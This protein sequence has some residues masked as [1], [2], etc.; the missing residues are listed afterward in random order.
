MVD[1]GGNRYA[2]CYQAGREKQTRLCTSY[3]G[4]TDVCAGELQRTSISNVA[5]QVP[6]GLA[7]ATFDQPWFVYAQEVQTFAPNAAGQLVALQKTRYAYEPALQAGTAGAQQYGN[8][9]RVEE[10]EGVGG[11]NFAT[12]PLRTTTTRYYP[13]DSQWLVNQPAVTQVYTGTTT[14]FAETRHYY[15]NTTNYALAPIFGQLKR[16]ESLSVL[17]GAYQSNPASVSQYFEYENGNLKWT[18]DANGNQTTYFYD[19]WYKAFR[20]CAQNAANLKAKATY[21]GVPGDGACNPTAGSALTTPGAAFGQVEQTEDTNGVRNRTT[22]DG[23]GRPQTVTLATGTPEQA[24]Q[25]YSYRP[26]AGI[27]LNAP[28]WVHTQ[29]QDNAGGDNYLH[30]WTFYDGFGRAIETQTEADGGQH[31]ED[32]RSYTFRDA[33]ERESPPL[34]KPGNVTSSATY[35]RRASFQMHRGRRADGESVA[36]C[37]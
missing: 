12:A 34:L 19:P 5:E 29:Q 3:T 11:L 31:V 37:S 15:D 24:L 25:S 7:V 33:P 2:W 23:L 4:S 27:G 16:V 13:N 22:Y 14:L 10:Y 28:F 1:G 35:D 8:R 30:T 18:K 36:E 26:F 20:V 9:T 32:Y 6:A 21:Y 17:N